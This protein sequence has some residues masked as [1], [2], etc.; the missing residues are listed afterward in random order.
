MSSSETIQI[1]LVRTR[2][3]RINQPLEE[4]HEFEAAI[5]KYANWHSVEG[6]PGAPAIKAVV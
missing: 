1:T 6:L 5:Q 2:V 3:Q 4:I